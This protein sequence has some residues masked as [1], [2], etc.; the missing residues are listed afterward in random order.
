MKNI[1]LQLLCKEQHLNEVVTLTA[2]GMAPPA[3]PYNE[4][5]HVVHTQ[6]N[7]D[8]FYNKVALLSNLFSWHR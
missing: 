1:V 5:P 3:R 7:L 4:D 2:A 6:V 8:T